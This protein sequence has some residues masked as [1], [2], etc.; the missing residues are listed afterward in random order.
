MLFCVVGRGVGERRDHD[1]TT[2]NSGV[3]PHSRVMANSRI[4]TL[5]FFERPP[6]HPDFKTITSLARNPDHQEKK[7]QFTLGD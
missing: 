5:I 4:I 1:L 2:Q 3:D 7:A 6:M